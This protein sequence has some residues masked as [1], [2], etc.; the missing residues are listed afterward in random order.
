MAGTVTS[1]GCGRTAAAMAQNEQTTDIP[2]LSSSHRQQTKRL[3]V[4]L[5][6]SE[7]HGLVIAEC[8]RALFKTSVVSSFI[9]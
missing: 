9:H 5:I 2:R 8:K 1:S 6:V 4:G 3:Q 7:F